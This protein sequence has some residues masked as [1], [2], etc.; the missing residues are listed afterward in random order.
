MTLYNR[1]K[2]L[3]DSEIFA[4]NCRFDNTVILRESNVSKYKSIQTKIICKMTF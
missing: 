3:L 1:Q 4:Q 2:L